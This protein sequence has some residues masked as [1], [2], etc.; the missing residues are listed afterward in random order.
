MR[1]V[2]VTCPANSA[3]VFMH[4]QVDEVVPPLVIEVACR[5]CRR[6]MDPR[7]RLVVHRYNGAGESVETVV[8]PE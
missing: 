4:L 3:R 1:T 8:T 7:P 6:D 2:V 5:D